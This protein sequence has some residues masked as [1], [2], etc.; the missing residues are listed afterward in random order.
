MNCSF[1]LLF[2]VFPCFSFGL[3]FAR[4]LYL[5]FEPW[6]LSFVVRYWDVGVFVVGVLTCLFVCVFVVLIVCFLC[7]CFFCLLFFCVF[8]CLFVCLFVCVSVCLF[9]C[10]H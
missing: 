6:C 5:S 3:L 9:L 4:R 2:D 8:V 10:Y 1:S 7:V